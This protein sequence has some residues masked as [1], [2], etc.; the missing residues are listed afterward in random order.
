MP[1]FAVGRAGESRCGEQGPEPHDTVTDVY[2]SLC[3]YYLIPGLELT[4]VGLFS[5]AFW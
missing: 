3:E 4:Y 1:Q 2:E 5:S